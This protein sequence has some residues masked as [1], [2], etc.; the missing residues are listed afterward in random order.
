MAICIYKYGFN[1]ELNGI[2][3]AQQDYWR[4]FHISISERRGA[5]PRVS[6]WAGF[7]HFKTK[8]VF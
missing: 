7:F 5:P 1:V 4:R 3:A 6:H 8:E 2:N